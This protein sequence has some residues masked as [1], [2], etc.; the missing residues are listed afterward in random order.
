MAREKPGVLE[1]TRAAG[2]YIQARHR[3]D[4]EDRAA[5]EAEAF[6]AIF[7]PGHPKTAEVVEAA[8]SRKRK[9]PRCP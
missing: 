9:P 3:N 8:R 1:R 6:M 5:I 2:T 4:T 7:H